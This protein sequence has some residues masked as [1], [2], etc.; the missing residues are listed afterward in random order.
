MHPGLG[1]RLIS[2]A[3]IVAFVLAAAI[4]FP[5]SVLLLI[6]VGISAVATLEF[7]AFL[8][9]AGIP[10]FNIVGVIAGALLHVVTWYTYYNP[11][12]ISADQA[13]IFILL[14][15]TVFVVIRTFP[16]KNNVKPIDTIAGTLL[17]FLYVPFLFN[18]LVRLLMGW[19]SG[20]G[21]LLIIYMLLVVKWTDGGAYFVGCA[22]GKH[23]LFPRISPAKTWEGLMGGLGTGALVSLIV[24]FACGGNLG[25]VSF[26]LV[27]AIILGVLLGIFGTV[28]D[29]AESMFK[30]AA[31]VKDSSKAIRGMGGIL[32][33]IDSILFAAP[34]IYV[35]ARL[36]LAAN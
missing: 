30:R 22:C 6:M 31:G 2:A 15:M 1:K 34:L 10:N 32:D 8:D 23:K 13:E 29:L 4:W 19:P 18:F 25:V 21:R 28:G 3:V 27:D 26:D 11:S 7:Y 17:G 9:E 16:Q 35:Y 14:G 5:A 12:C 33:V 24:Y 36:F 20:E